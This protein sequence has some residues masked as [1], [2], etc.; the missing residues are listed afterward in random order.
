MDWILLFM[1]CGMG[2]L[3]LFGMIKIFS[4]FYDKENK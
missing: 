4:Y 2:I 3:S 1:I